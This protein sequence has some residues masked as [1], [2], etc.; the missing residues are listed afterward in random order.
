[1]HKAALGT[2]LVFTAS[3]AVVGSWVARIPAVV[4]RLGITNG[5]LGRALLALGIGS[6]VS[7]PLTGIACRRLG[8][9]TWVAATA[10]VAT[11]ALSAVGLA[12]DLLTLTGALFLLGLAYGSWD[13]AMNVQG[14]HVDRQ[15]GREWMPRYHACWSLGSIGG[16]AAGSLAA[17]TGL[18]VAT[19]LAMAALASLAV[20]L[21]GL[22]LYLDERV[23]TAEPGPGER[24]RFR[25]S[26]VILVIGLVTFCATVAE[27][28]AGDWLALYLDT[29]RHFSQADAA[30]GYTAFAAAMT[31]GRFA[32]STAVARLGRASAVRLGALAGLAGVLATVLAPWTLA[33]YTGAIFWGLGICLVFPAAI[34][35]AGETGR[36]AAAIAVVTSIGYGSILVGPPLIGA[37]ADVTGLGHALLGLAV[38]PLAIALLAPVLATRTAEVPAHP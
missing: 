6:L 2:A 38:L 25:A 30:L 21:A 4:E 27:G 33:T 1:M 31:V 11:V 13:V 17:R 12:G 26:R 29:G 7:M 15:A 22:T 34:S 14:S 24:P 35:A 16:A 9:R 37:L 19:H 5:E 3:G 18:D 36:P 10:V 23:G 20:T 28:A 32:G 8:S